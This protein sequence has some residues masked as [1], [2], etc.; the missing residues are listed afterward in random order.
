MEQEAAGHDA[1]S[2]AAQETHRACV[3][4]VDLH[5]D[6][7]RDERDERCDDEL[8]VAARREEGRQAHDGHLTLSEGVD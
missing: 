1:E 7:K 2:G 5:V 3:V 8:L 4:R 6:T